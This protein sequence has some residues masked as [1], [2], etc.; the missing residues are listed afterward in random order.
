M[1]MKSVLALSLFALTAAF[2]TNVAAKQQT[3]APAEKC[4]TGLSWLPSFKPAFRIPCCWDDSNFLAGVE[5]AYARQRTV[6]ET[7]FVAPTFLPPINNYANY[8]ATVVNPGYILGG[9]AG[10]QMRVCR[11]LFG[12]EGNLDATG[13]FKRPRTFT[14]Q[15]YYV[16]NSH[17]FAGSVVTDRG[18]I[19]GL[20]TR[21]GFFVTP[22]FLPYVRLGAQTSRDNVTYQV[23]SG[24]TAGGPIA[25][26]WDYSSLKKRTIGVVA[27]VGVEFPAFIGPSTVRLEYN[28]TQMQNLAIADNVIPIVGTHN[29][30]HPQNNLFKVA[31][32]WNLC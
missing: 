16:T 27:G 6:F 1:R 4:T 2:G 32:V 9:L 24:T 11:F 18:P 29:F 23:F 28:F 31:W 8:T 12:L 3:S 14:F 30:R 20:T 26:S 10:W 25:T 15:D 7:N 21:M 22:G 17:W 5:F 13:L 19:L